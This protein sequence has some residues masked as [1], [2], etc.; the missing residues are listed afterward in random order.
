[1]LDTLPTAKMNNTLSPDIE[2]EN[3]GA[4]ITTFMPVKVAIVMARISWIFL[5]GS[6]LSATV[7]SII[8]LVVGKFG[9]TVENDGWK[10]RQMLIANCDMQRTML[11]DNQNL[12]LDDKGRSKW[13]R[14]RF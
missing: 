6:L 13:E 1:M 12:L 5:L 8:G 10:S 2:H 11:M 9:I 3:Q 7:L 4:T 14:F